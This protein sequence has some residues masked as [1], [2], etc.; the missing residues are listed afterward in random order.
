[1]TIEHNHSAS[2]YACLGNRGWQQQTHQLTTRQVAQS[3]VPDK[4]GLLSQPKSL[5]A[6]KE[7]QRHTTRRYTI[8]G[9]TLRLC[10]TAT[11]EAADVSPKGQTA[12]DGGK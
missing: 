8:S 12:G 11:V 7:R 3:L 4:L 1:M 5:E 6:Q 2:S 10:T 9:T